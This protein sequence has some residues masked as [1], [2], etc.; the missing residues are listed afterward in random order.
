MITTYPT[1]PTL[2]AKTETETAI[3]F[4][5]RALGFMLR[6]NVVAPLDSET[7]E[8]ALHASIVPMQAQG[9][10]SPV[11][12]DK[13]HDLR[14]AINQILAARRRV[15][16]EE[17]AALV[18]RSVPPTN[19]TRGGGPSTVLRRQPV[20]MIPPAGATVSRF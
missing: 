7:L 12:F 14:L 10:T 3:A 9:E 19:A 4:G 1:I 8:A 2:D 6:T 13:V 20:P 18:L 16:A 11:V 15:L 17:L 5:L